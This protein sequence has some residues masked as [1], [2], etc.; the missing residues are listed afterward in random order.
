MNEGT[1]VRQKGWLAGGAEECDGHTHASQ[2]NQN[3][4]FY[5][6]GEPFLT[7]KKIVIV[8]SHLLWKP[9]SALSK[10]WHQPSQSAGPREQRVAQQLQ[11]LQLCLRKAAR[12]S[13]HRAVCGHPAGSEREEILRRVEWR[14]GSP[15]S[16]PL[17]P[18]V[19]ARPAQLFPFGFAACKK[20]PGTALA[21]LLVVDQHHSCGLLLWNR[22]A[23]QLL[24]SG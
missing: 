6:I 19:P 7:R 21:L 23:P 10:G 18:C 24:R 1:F 2:H 15:F 13:E 3:E 5:I 20:V 8:Q 17:H 11:P 12:N 9:L 16:A 4:K 22:A 14:A